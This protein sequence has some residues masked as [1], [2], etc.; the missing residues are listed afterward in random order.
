MIHDAKEQKEAKPV[1]WLRL[2]GN[3][4]AFVQ[5]ENIG[6]LQAA[7]SLIPNAT[8][9]GHIEAIAFKK[10]EAINLWHR[11]LPLYILFIPLWLICIA[12]LY[13][14]PSPNLQSVVVLCMIVI[15]AIA[16][17]LTFYR[18]SLRYQSHLIEARENL[19]IRFNK[20]VAQLPRQEI[21]TQ[22]M[23]I[24]KGCI[25]MFLLNE[26]VKK[27]AGY[28]SIFNASVDE[29]MP[30][31]KK[32]IGFDEKNFKKVLPQ[33]RR[34]DDIVLDTENARTTH[35]GYLDILIQHYQ[36]IGEN[37]LEQQAIA[38]QTFLNRTPLKA[39]G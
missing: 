17:L 10:R 7:I 14:E 9:P 16:Y 26:L 24:P 2:I 4:I 30:F 36:V 1:N 33:Y 34:R 23:P 32:M 39:A 37:A 3:N 6:R 5:Y 25:P 27:E 11:F 13:N 19:L 22:T 29:V 35:I 38:L 21:R 31:C 8:T 15:S 12:C 28:S 20:E 18:D